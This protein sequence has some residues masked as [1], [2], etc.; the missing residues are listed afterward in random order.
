MHSIERS[1]VA[2]SRLWELCDNQSRV[3]RQRRD[4]PDNEKWSGRWESNRHGRRVR[5]LKTCAL[6]RMPMP[7]VISV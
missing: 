3:L 1:V 5:S 4:T 2:G 7:S 6:V